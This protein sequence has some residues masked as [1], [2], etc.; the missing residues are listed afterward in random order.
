MSG[1]EI[2]VWEGFGINMKNINV[3]LHLHFSEKNIETHTYTRTH[4]IHVF[5]YCM[6]V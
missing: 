5:A 1:V 4:G 3:E 2:Q 6:Y